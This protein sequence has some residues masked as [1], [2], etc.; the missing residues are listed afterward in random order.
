MMRSDMP[1][2]MRSPNAPA[3]KGY[4]RPGFAGRGPMAARPEVTTMPVRETGRRPFKK[5]GMV[6]PKGNGCCAKNKPCKMS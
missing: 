5:G 4:N 6:T 1:E 3:G 2:Q